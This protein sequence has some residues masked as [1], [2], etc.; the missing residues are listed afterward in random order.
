[1]LD[2]DI[3]GSNGQLYLRSVTGTDIGAKQGPGQVTDVSGTYCTFHFHP[4]GSFTYDL[5]PTVAA[6][7]HAGDMVEEKLQYYKIS[8]GKGHTDVG[9]ITLDING[10]SD[11]PTAVDDHY[12][13]S[14]NDAISGNVL[15]NDIPGA[16]G[17]LF[18][19]DVTGT[20]IGAKEGPGQITDIHGTYGTFHFQPRRS[21][22]L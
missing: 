5:D 7:L 16:N 22:Y 17:Q 3:P 19:R 15:D 20:D 10:V 13:F 14:E 6:G 1:M 11:R 12:T 8:D 21:F 2:N 4:D 18:L 9:V